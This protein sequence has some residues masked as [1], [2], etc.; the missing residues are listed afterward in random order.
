MNWPGSRREL[1]LEY[2]AEL[3]IELH[4]LRGEC[5]DVAR[6]L[7]SPG[8]TDPAGLEQCARLDEALDLAHRVLVGAVAQIRTE[9]ARHA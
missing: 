4:L 8:S 1:P 3:A 9:R 7:T 2:A 5:C 6:N